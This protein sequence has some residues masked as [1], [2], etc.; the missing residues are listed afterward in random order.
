MAH[1]NNKAQQKSQSTVKIS[2][3]ISEK[4][5]VYTTQTFLN[6]KQLTFSTLFLCHSQTHYIFNNQWLYRIKT[7]QS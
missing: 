4:K 3:D 1:H 7:V 5:I 2:H 6:S